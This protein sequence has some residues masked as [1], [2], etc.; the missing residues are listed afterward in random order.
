MKR[1]RSFSAASSQRKFCKVVRRNP[2]LLQPISQLRN[3]RRVRLIGVWKPRVLISDAARPSFHAPCELAL[4][5]VL[6]VD[7]R[8]VRRSFANQSTSMAL[9][10]DSNSNQLETARHAAFGADPSVS[11][12]MIWVLPTVWLTGYPGI[13]FPLVPLDCETDLQ[14]GEARSA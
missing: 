1:E 9:S 13:Q 6:T 14:T 7:Y 10:S 8:I 11:R 3:R 4:L 5:Y 12:I 2:Y